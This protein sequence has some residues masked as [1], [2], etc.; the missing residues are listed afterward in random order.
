VCMSHACR[1][2]QRTAGGV[3]F[4]GAGIKGGYEMPVMDAGPLGEQKVP[5]TMEHVSR[6]WS[7][8]FFMGAKNIQ[9]GNDNLFHKYCWE[10]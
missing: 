9:L 10:S 2:S 7:T 8:D 1:S 3:R 4:L 5:L 6:P